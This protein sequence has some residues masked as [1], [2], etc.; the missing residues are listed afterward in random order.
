MWAA[1]YL[2]PLLWLSPFALT[3]AAWLL[4]ARRFGLLL[5]PYALSAAVAG[6][7]SYGP[8]VRGALPVV[9]PRAVGAEEAQLKEALRAR[10]VR[11]AK[12]NYWLA[13]RLTFLF[14]EDPVVVPFDPELDR[15]PPYRAR[16]ERAERTAELF[17]P[18]EPRDAPDPHARALDVAG[19]LYERMEV[20]GFTALLVTR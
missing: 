8:L 17:H 6:W 18:S 3:P 19:A 12:A 4:G 16:C 11:C 15:Y 20:G 5:A 10:G 1:R 2:A 7:V 9:H 14:E 13:Y